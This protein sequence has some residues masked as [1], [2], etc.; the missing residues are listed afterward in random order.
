MA[1]PAP[2]SRTSVSLLAP[3]CIAAAL[4]VGW[5]MRRSGGDEIGKMNVP[6]SFDLGALAGDELTFTTDT[7][8]LFPSR[9][10]KAVPEGCTLQ[11]VLVQNG[12]D[13]ASTSCDLFS[14]SGSVNIASQ[15]IRAQ[16]DGKTRLTTDGQHVGCGLAVKAAG[17]ATLRATST[18]DACVTHAYGV[19]AHVRVTHAAK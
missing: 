2:K 12:A 9:N 18:M 1:P 15:E 17:P 8:V 11:I 4:G 6:G 10:R 5:W 16:Q 13:V 14:T 19:I 7:D 3:L